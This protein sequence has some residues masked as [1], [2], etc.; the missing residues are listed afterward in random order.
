MVQ[1][2]HVQGS[3]RGGGG[4]RVLRRVLPHG[5][6]LGGELAGRALDPQ[7]VR[8]GPAAPQIQL[9]GDV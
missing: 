7:L 8:G 9:E 3:A 4:V 6:H 2:V 5:G 1:Q